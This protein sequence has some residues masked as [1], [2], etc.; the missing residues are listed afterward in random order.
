[1]IPLCIPELR[2]NEWLYVKDCLDSGWVSSVGGY[3]DRFEREL[4][5]RVGTRF[6][7]A[8]VNGTA[9][10]H[11]ALLVAGVQP[12]DEV[13][14][15]TVTFI[16][17]ANAIRYVGAWPV[18]I[19]AE[20]EYWQMDTE[21]VVYFLEHQCRWQNGE[22]RNQ[23]TDR[24]IRA[25]LPVHILGHPVDLQ[26]ILDVAKKF[27]LIVIEDATESLGANYRGR[28]A[29][30]LGDIA[31]FSFNGNKLI[32][33]G[34]G[35]MIVTN[36]EAWARHAKHLTTQAKGDPVEYIHDEIGYNYRLT[37]L[38][39]ALGV[40]QLE[41][42]DAYI[43]C[44]R[45]V[46]SRY[47]ESLGQIRGVT[48]MSQAPWA[49]SSFWLY[50]VLVDPISFGCSSRQVLQLLAAASIQTRPIWQPIHLNKPYQPLARGEYPVAAMLYERGLSLPCSVGLTDEDQSRV[51]A[52][53]SA[54]KR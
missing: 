6:A 17:P 4:A 15:P 44:K 16:A 18:F 37:N 28:P 34:G 8:T 1:M 23:A 51:I 49:S 5:T 32:T 36:H 50:T 3:V 45:R 21:K 11:I 33:T 29:G 41:Q 22:L 20:P 30:Q 26:P 12:D 10:L 42:L 40:A 53:F 27:D 31:C 47:T 14:V 46:A 9:S 25:I 35:G 19:D 54:L 7:V 39:A 48:P 52:T 13:L 24:R 2:G 38:Q 43:G